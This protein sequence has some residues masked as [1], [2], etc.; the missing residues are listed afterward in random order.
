L[1][2]IVVAA[3]EEVP[4]GTMRLVEYESL[5][6]GVFNCGGELFAIE[7]RCT[8][9]DGPLCDGFWEPSTCTIECPRHGASFD[10][11]TG[12]ALTLPAYLP[13]RTFPVRVEG[14]VVSLDVD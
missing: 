14:G 4:P 2:E 7:D 11:R 5:R 1:T 9:D 8:H 10:L 3:L 12:R 13:A 6:V